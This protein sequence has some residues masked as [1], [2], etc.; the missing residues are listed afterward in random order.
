MLANDFLPSRGQ[1]DAVLVSMN[2]AVHVLRQA[3]DP[4]STLVILYYVTFSMCAPVQHVII[5]VLKAYADNCALCRIVMTFTVVLWSSAPVLCSYSTRTMRKEST[6]RIV[7][8]IFAVEVTYEPS[9]LSQIPCVP[10]H[11]ACVKE[12]F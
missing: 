5:E 10:Q 4:S 8:F 7:P 3:R 12:G 1:R 2:S 9:L 6:Y 11:I